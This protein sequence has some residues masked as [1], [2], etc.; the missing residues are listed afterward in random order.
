MMVSNTADYDIFLT[1]FDG[2]VVERVGTRLGEAD[3]D[4]NPLKFTSTSL[5]EVVFCSKNQQWFFGGHHQ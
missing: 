2:V 4:V 1:F 5:I 3:R